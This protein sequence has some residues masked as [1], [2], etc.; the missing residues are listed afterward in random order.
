M[1]GHNPFNGT[2]VPNLVKKSETV[3]GNLVFNGMFDD[4]FGGGDDDDNGESWW[5]GLIPDAWKDEISEKLKELKGKVKKVGAFAKSQ[6]EY[7]TGSDEII[8]IYTIEWCCPNN[9]KRR[10]ITYGK[11]RVSEDSSPRGGPRTQDGVQWNAGD[12]YIKAFME[13]ANG[14]TYSN[15]REN[16]K[17]NTVDSLARMYSKETT[18]GKKQANFSESPFGAPPRTVEEKV[19]GEPTGNT[20][21]VPALTIQQL[22][23]NFVERGDSIGPGCE[24]DATVGCMNPDAENYNPNADCP[25]GSCSC[26]FDSNGKRRKFDDSGKCYTV[27][28][29]DTGEGRNTHADG[30]CS[31]C[32]SGFIEKSGKCVKPPVDCKVSAYEYGDCQEDGTKVGTR[33]ITQQPAHGGR[34]CENKYPDGNGGVKLTQTISCNYT[35][36]STSGGTGGTITT[37][38]DKEEPETETEEGLPI[39]WIVGGLAVV[40]LGFFAMNR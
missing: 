10:R 5:E 14:V 34:S 33:T 24:V 15:G 6:W 12:E 26:G 3:S 38:S 25:D 1:F 40:G 18:G 31:T 22:V 23:D 29:A 17:W 27:P 35:P 19:D 8:E 32:K 30:S 13:D 2:H 9:G 21:Q 7:L 11:Y 16:L 4:F 36:P 37:M 20:Q 28:C 39:G